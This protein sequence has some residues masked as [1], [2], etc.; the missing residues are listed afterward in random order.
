MDMVKPVVKW[1]ATCY[2]TKRI[3]EYLSIAFRQAREGR[4]GPVF[5]ELP[6][7][8]LN[9]SVE[10]KEVPMPSPSTRGF[11]YCAPEPALKAAAEIITAP[12]SLFLAQRGGFQQPGIILERFIEKTGLPLF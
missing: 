3:P 12:G 4:P 1:T 5:L 11:K 7:D 6:P 10:E 9:V 2:D 8:I